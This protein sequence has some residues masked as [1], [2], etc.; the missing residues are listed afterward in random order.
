MLTQQ[1][2]VQ[3]GHDTA[4][5]RDNTSVVEASPT[6]PED[7]V[8]AVATDDAHLVPV[9]EAKRYRKR[10]QAAEKILEDLK[11]ELDQKNKQMAEQQQLLADLQRQREIDELLLDAEAVDLESTR[12]LTEIALEEMDE[13]DAETAIAQLRRRKPFLFRSTSRVAAAAQ[14]AKAISEPADRAMSQAAAEAHATGSRHDVLRYLR[15]RR[16]R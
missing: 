3:Q 2:P 13:P 10:A 6:N 1:D 12:L 8:E 15:L 7:L 9:S 16:K 11:Q 5:A 4:P 14:G